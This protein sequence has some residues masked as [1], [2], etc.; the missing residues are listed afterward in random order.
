[1]SS[2][3]GA[4]YGVRSC[5]APSGLWQEMKEAFTTYTPVVGLGFVRPPLQ[6]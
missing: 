6:G 4:T 3:E 2:P 5:H 1:M